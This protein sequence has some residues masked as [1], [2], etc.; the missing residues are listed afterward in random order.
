LEQPSH[1]IPHTPHTRQNDAPLFIYIGFPM[2]LSGLVAAAMRALPSPSR[3]PHPNP[4]A[5]KRSLVG[6]GLQAPA[7]G[8]WDRVQHF[9]RQLEREG[10]N[11]A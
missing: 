8:D 1:S 4:A 9:T 11:D 10:L 7:R 3:P 2:D 5:R 6:R